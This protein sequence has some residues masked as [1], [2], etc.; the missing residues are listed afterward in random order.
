MLKNKA[1]VTMTVCIGAHG[2][3]DDNEMILGVD[4]ETMQVNGVLCSAMW[5]MLTCSAYLDQSTICP[6]VKCLTSQLI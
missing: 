2:E 5:C 4:N 3:Y 6:S 1:A